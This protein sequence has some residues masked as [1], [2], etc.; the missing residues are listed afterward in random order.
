MIEVEKVRYVDKPVEKIVK[1]DRNVYKDN[2]IEVEKT[3]Y[4]EKPVPVDL[5]VYEVEEKVIEVPVEVVVLKVNP[6]PLCPLPIPAYSRLSEFAL[7]RPSSDCEALLE[8]GLSLSM[9]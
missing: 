8:D 6:L 4:E 7:C 5:C 3:V 1:V 9:L 2:I